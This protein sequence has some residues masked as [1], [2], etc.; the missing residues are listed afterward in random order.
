VRVVRG[1]RGR[2]A[3]VSR[4]PGAPARLVLD[5][6]QAPPEAAAVVRDLAIGVLGRIEALLAGPATDLP[7]D[8]RAALAALANALAEQAAG[9]ATVTILETPLAR[10]WRDHPAG[11]P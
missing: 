9:R 10:A 3:A 7:A 1:H 6:G 5:L 8:L 11:R 4:A 2:G